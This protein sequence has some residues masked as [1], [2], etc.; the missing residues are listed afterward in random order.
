M[1]GSGTPSNQSKAP[2]PKSMTSSSLRHLSRGNVPPLRQR[3]S[4]PLVRRS[5]TRA[6]RFRENWRSNRLGAEARC[7]RD[8]PQWETGMADF[9]LGLDIWKLRT[10]W[11][12]CRARFPLA[13][14]APGRNAARRSMFAWRHCIS[15]G[16]QFPGGRISTSFKWM[17]LFSF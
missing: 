11:R 1:I 4:Q 2:F 7:L 8:G 12:R 13:A 10:H 14:R 5:D 6:A 16:Q 17:C 15:P 9:L 3:P